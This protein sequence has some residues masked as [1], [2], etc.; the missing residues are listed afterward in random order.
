MIL[1]KDIKIIDVRRDDFHPVD[2]YDPERFLAT[3]FAEP[4]KAVVKVKREWVKGKRFV[5]SQ[6]R[7]VVIGWSKIVQDALGLPFEVFENQERRRE[8]DYQENTKLRK[9]IR[10]LETKT[11]FQFLKEKF[12]KGK[13]VGDE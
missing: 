13:G 8:S 1:V 2:H 9:K 6:G 3:D 11:L 5:N 7:I 12:F 4:T 10:E